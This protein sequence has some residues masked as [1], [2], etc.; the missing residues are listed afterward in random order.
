ML[1]SAS[2]RLLRHSLTPTSTTTTYIAARPITFATG[3][4]RK[5][6]SLTGI[7]GKPGRPSPASSS[8][9]MSRPST[10]GENTIT[11]VAAGTLLAG[12]WYIWEAGRSYIVGPEVEKYEPHGLGTHREG[13]VN[14]DYV[15]YDHWVEM[16]RR[17]GK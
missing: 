4:I 13:T 14:R 17:K 16:H 15:N 8:R 2:A 11:T 5:P 9:L 10:W 12:S 3:N 6:V 7:R 1:R